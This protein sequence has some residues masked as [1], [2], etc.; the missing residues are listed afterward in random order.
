LLILELSLRRKFSHCIFQIGV[1]TGVDA[2]T[3]KYDAYGHR[4]WLVYYNGPEATWQSGLAVGADAARDIRVLATENTVSDS[5]AD[6]SLLHCRQRDPASTF[7][8]QLIADAGGTFH[9]SV[10]AGESFRIEASVDLQNWGV[11]TEEET[12][13]LLQPGATSFA[14]APKR[15]FRLSFAE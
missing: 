10:L 3:A 13:P 12:Q 9:L 2:V 8:L 1:A 5:S 7:R 14:D 6:F 4:H 15:F 11:L